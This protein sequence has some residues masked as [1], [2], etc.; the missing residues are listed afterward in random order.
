[1]KNCDQLDFKSID[2]LVIHIIQN[3]GEVHRKYIN[4]GK[5]ITV[6]HAEVKVVDPLMLIP[7]C[8]YSDTIGQSSEFVEIKPIVVDEID[9]Y[10]RKPA[11]IN[12]KIILMD[13]E[14]IRKNKDWRAIPRKVGINIENQGFYLMR[15]NRQIG[16]ALSLGIYT[17]HPDFN[18][19]RGEISFP[20]VLDK[21]FGVQ[22]NKSRFSL[23]PSIRDI[24]KERLKGHL[25]QIRKVVKDWN[26]KADAEESETG[27]RPSEEIAAKVNKLLKNN[28]YEPSLK[29][30]K[31]VEEEANRKKEEEIK[32]LLMIQNLQKKKR[33]KK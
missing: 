6:N 21:Y 17:K 12:I 11:K 3:I 18:Y 19:F 1:L 31:E 10:T 7:G 29:E 20:P 13:L 4:A 9:P 23:D 33:K 2:K 14:T 16:R 5:K 26:S 15:H 8:L 30:I 22:T 28:K 25:E 24:I 27:I 32:K